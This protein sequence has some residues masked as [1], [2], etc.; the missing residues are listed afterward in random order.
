MKTI[1]EKAETAIM[2]INAAIAEMRSQMKI[3]A[4]NKP[5]ADKLVT[6]ARRKAKTAHN[7]YF[8]RRPKDE[9]AHLGQIKEVGVNGIIG[10]LEK[11]YEDLNAVCEIYFAAIPLM[12]LNFKTRF[13]SR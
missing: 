1:S 5:A 10:D 12:K 3:Q 7:A 13:E 11:A 2:T 9:K 8:N 6:A 4:I